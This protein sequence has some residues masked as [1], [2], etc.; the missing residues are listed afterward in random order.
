MSTTPAAPILIHRQ[1]LLSLQ[2]AIT[3]L[4]QGVAAADFEGTSYSPSQLP[5]LY[6]L[7][8][9]LQVKAAIESIE[10]GN[11]SYAINGLT[12]TRADL[13]VLYERDARLEAKAGRAARGGI[14]I[15]YGVP[16]G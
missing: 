3:L 8:E 14:G 2:A 7:V 12:Y 9:R 4:Q 13:R 16:H 1:R 11:Q 15:R 10:V 6:G 5:T